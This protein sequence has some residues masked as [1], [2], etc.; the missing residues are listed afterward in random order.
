MGFINYIYYSWYTLLLKSHN[1]RE[2]AQFSA[3]LAVAMM[4]NFN[5]IILSIALAK[6]DIFPFLFANK[7]EVIGGI[8]LLMIFSLIYFL[9]KKRYVEIA[10][11]F[12][13]GK[14]SVVYKNNVVFYLYM[15]FTAT[16]FVVVSL[17]RPGYLPRLHK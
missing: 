16:L 17:Y 12:S 14:V 1:H 4:L 15:I 9:R 3:A 8:T 2:I 6:F 7:S 10:D 13:S 5:I 11:R